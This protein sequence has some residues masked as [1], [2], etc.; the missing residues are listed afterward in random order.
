MFDITPGGTAVASAPDGWYVV[1]LKTVEA[2]DP[3]TDAATVKQV[4]EQLTEGMRGDI[5]AQFEK[6]LRNR[7]PVSVRQAEIDRLL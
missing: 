6:A 1:Q 2:P 7:Y 4:T 5:L 3:A